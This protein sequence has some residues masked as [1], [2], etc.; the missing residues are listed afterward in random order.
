MIS[1][2]RNV[3]IFGIA[4]AVLATLLMTGAISLWCGWAAVASVVIALHLRQVDQPNSR[5]VWVRREPRPAR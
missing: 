3:V 4:V 5:G 2:Y 1:S